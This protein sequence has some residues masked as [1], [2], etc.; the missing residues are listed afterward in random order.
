MN[1]GCPSRAAD[2]V[3]HLAREA[4]RVRLEYLAA[5]EGLVIYRAVDG[6]DAVQ[7]RWRG[8]FVPIPGTRRTRR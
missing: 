5:D 2:H 7:V 4:L 1:P 6:E 3:V 8:P